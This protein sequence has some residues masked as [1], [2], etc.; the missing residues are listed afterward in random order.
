MFVADVPEASVSNELGQWQSQFEEREFESQSGTVMPYRIARPAIKSPR[1]LVLV[2]HGKG[3]MGADN[4]S[5]LTPFATSWAGLHDD[6]ELAPI[7][8][9]PQVDQRSANYYRCGG[10]R[11]ASRPGPSFGVLLEFLDIYAKDKAVDP[12]RIYMAGFS[13]GGAT[14]MHLA[15]ARPKAVA[16]VAVFGAVPPAKD[17]AP[18]LKQHNLL[19][20]QGTKDRNHP[21]KLMQEW[22]DGLNAS[23]GAAM[24]DIR[25][26]MKHKIPDDM[27]VD[28]VWRRQLLQQARLDE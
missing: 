11:C 25:K 13:M 22:I 15:L 14:A 17:R 6:P 5:H 9:A 16:G 2:L 18:E 1:P 20:V 19:V 3:E 7:I 24:F 12:G 26:G 8:V 27:V 28:Q 10:K 21:I 4:K 23:G